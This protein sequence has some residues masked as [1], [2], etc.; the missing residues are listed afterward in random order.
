[1]ISANTLYVGIDPASGHKDFSF[2]VLDSNLNVVELADADL[3]DLL[4]RVLL[5]SPPAK[6]PDHEPAEVSRGASRQ[7]ALHSVL[8]WLLGA[9]GVPMLRTRARAT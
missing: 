4:V 9:N 7:H 5:H 2:A 6:L 3:A 1:M 8:L